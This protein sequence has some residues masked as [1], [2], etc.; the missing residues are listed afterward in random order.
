MRLEEISNREHEVLELISFENTTREI[1]SKLYISHHTV[2]SHRKNLMAKLGARNTAGLIRR[3]FEFGVLKVYSASLIFVL[4]MFS[5]A[6]H[7]DS[8]ELAMS[9]P[10]ILRYD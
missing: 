3:A 6:L 8:C 7:A 5:S 2:V 1:A 4:I 9:A 10:I